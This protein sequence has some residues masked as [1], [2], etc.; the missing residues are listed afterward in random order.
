MTRYG[1]TAAGSQRWACPSCK[2]TTTRKYKNDAKL[3][4]DFLDWLLSKDL[5][6]DM[7]GQG[8]SFRRKTAQFWKLWPP[9]PTIDEVHRVIYVDG[10]YLGRKAVILI[11]RSDEHILGWYLARTENSAAYTALLSRIAPPDMVVTD[12]G[13]G[14]EKA[15]KRVWR[16][17][18]VQRCLFH[19]F[20]QVKRYTTSR[21]K[22]EA[23]AELYKLALELL[24]IK[25]LKQASDWVDGYLNWC[26]KW[27]D[28][29]GEKTFTDNSWTW[30]HERLVKAR[31]SLNTLVN[32]G[33]LFTYLDLE[34]SEN[35]SLPATN[36]KLEGGVNAPLRQLLRE[37]R[38]MNIDRRIKAI[39]W[40][41]YLHT[42]CPLSPTEM[43]KTMPTDEYINKL[44]LQHTKEKEKDGPERWGT[45]VMWSGFHHFGP[46][47]M[48]Y[49]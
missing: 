2:A 45:G 18:K 5:Q 39:F 28:F 11:A 16:K 31:N 37:H 19:V 47:R 41:C 6:K 24:H 43:L 9:S 34:L 13:S 44:Y 3:L 33:T 21:P 12:G 20:S 29:L 14:F 46:Y 22:L 23:G 27:E 17:T 30:T 35:G 26:H 7:P 4:V 48:D 8:R 42:E 36:N 10:I 38:G 1:K 32:K 49:D 25:T 40:W 15:R